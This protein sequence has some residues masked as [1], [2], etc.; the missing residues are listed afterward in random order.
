VP[1]PEMILETEEG[2][3]KAR[4]ADGRRAGRLVAKQQFRASV[5]GP[6]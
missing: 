5:A 4:E 6:A 2:Q 3:G 1:V